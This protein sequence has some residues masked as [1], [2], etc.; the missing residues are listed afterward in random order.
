VSPF[1]ESM[2]QSGLNERKSRDSPLGFAD[3]RTIRML[4][5]FFYSGEID[6]NEENIQSSL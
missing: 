5:K 6:V 3:E 2:F 4:V 1:F